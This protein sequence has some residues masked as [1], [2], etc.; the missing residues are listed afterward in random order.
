M[1]EW[2]LVACYNQFKIKS[3]DLFLMQYRYVL[4]AER[5][6]RHIESISAT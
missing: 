3:K 2:S 4:E 6:Q 1:H 5:G